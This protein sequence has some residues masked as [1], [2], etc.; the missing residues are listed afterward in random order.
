MLP[1]SLYEPNIS[2]LIKEFGINENCLMVGTFPLSRIKR[3]LGGTPFY[4]YSRSAIRKRVEEVRQALPAGIK[5]NY[6]IKAN[7]MCPIV[8]DLGRVVDGFDCASAGEV[9]LALNTGVAASRISF[10]GP[11]KSS[12]EITMALAAGVV[13]VAESRNEI[14]LISTL[15]RE[16][17]VQPSVM[18]R[19]NPNYSLR[20]GP[21]KM[22]GQ[23]TQFG[24]EVDQVSSLLWEIKQLGLSLMGFHVF[25]GS[26]ILDQETLENSQR[27]AITL[28]S[29]LASSSPLPVERINIGGGFGIPYYAE[30]CQIALKPLGAN[31]EEQIRLNSKSCS[32]VQ[33][34]VELGRYLVGE[35]GVYICTVLDR[36]ESGGEI[37]VVTDGGMHHHLAA[38]GNLGGMLRRNF[39][40]VVANK[41]GDDQVETVT[42]TGRL[43]SPLDI[44]GRRVTLPRC[45]VGDLIA[46]FQSGAYGLTASPISFL[47]HPSAH[48]IY[49]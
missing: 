15:A 39:P 48:E 33:Y 36:K 34:E 32:A 5:L 10:T 40:I 8:Q 42:I 16:H 14:E 37:F 31:L 19:V 20:S 22:G 24:V 49:L 35:A 18:L 13:I 17:R 3:M 7:P 27:D 30:Q 41:L 9:H 12:E 46:I 28:T 47:G 25:A 23:P 2:R 44:L 4:A 29:S 21:L 38:S 45:A 6:A 26:Q 43:C 11:G 1:T